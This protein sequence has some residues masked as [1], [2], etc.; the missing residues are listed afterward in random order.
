MAINAWSMAIRGNRWQSACSSVKS[1]MPRPRTHCQ[2]AG[3]GGVGWGGVRCLVAK[4]LDQWFA[5]AWAPHCHSAVRMAQMHDRIPEMGK[6]GMRPFTIVH[7]QSSIHKHQFTV[8]PFTVI[9][10][11]R[12]LRG[13]KTEEAGNNPIPGK[14]KPPIH[15]PLT[16]VSHSM[17]TGRTT[18]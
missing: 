5:H 12:S 17:P 9:H 2:G 8:C 18:G 1:S 4:H 15:Y 7:S 6:H 11:G 10:V 14:H 3:R 13:E 16:Q